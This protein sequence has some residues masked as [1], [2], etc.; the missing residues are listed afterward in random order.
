MKINNYLRNIKIDLYF[1]VRYLAMGGSFLTTLMMLRVLSSSDFISFQIML[2]FFVILYWFIDFGSI[3]LMVLAKDDKILISKY[4]S[5]RTFRYVVLTVLMFIILLFVADLRIAL[6]F[7]AVNTDYFNDSMITYR[8]V[9][10][11]LDYL[12]ITLLVRKSAPLLFLFFSNSFMTDKTFEYFLLITIISN[13][14]WILKDL[15]NIPFSVKYVFFTDNQTKMNCLQQGGNFLQ[16]LDVPLLNF[17]SFTIIIPPY[18][19]A[20]KLFQI[21]SVF[22]H[23][24]IPRIMDANLEAISLKN[25]KKRIYSN[26]K[27]SVIM[28]F[29]IIC[30]TE[31]VFREMSVI[32]LTLDDRIMAYLL[33]IIGNLSIVTVQ[34]NALLKAL[35]NFRTLL[36]STLGST[37]IYLVS[38]V[39]IMSI[40]KVKWF[41]LLPQILNLS[42]EL[43]LQK[44]AFDKRYK[45]D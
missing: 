10:N 12:A 32:N 16:N 19:L 35:R 3:D 21:L 9:R 20:R 2:S 40:W 34:Q 15:F 30:F 4:S 28:S 13:I 29:F 7:I 42:A 25:I 36:I 27:L 43:F 5:G 38:I 8:S 24:Q 18:V 39:T 1:F 11:S 23:F 14:P 33:L 17:L 6:I 22:G 37:L 31:V 41:F 45:N 44:S 26:F